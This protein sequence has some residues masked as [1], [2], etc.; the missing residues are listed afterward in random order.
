MKKI[1]S[2]I[3]LAGMLVSMSACRDESLNP[4]P[5]WEYAVHGFLVWDGV[6]FNGKPLS[7]PQP[8]E[9]DYTRNFTPANT[10]NSKVNMKIR[11]VSLDNKLTV[12]KVEIYVRMVEYYND[13]EGNP[14]T[15]DLSG[16]GKGRLYSTLTAGSN[17]QYTN[18]SIEAS[19]VYELYKNATVKYDKVNAV[20]VFNNPARPRPAG[21]RFR[22]D[23]TAGYGD[24][25]SDDFIVTFKLYTADGKVFETWEP[26]SICGDPTPV[27]EANSN[28]QLTFGV[29]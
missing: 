10:D 23:E 24:V 6:A 9:V 19:K 29:Y 12:N 13:P 16:N 14:K 8:Y 3:T 11:W 5:A 7:R 2:L 22:T 21:N 25:F 4:V 27:S 17:R 18:F 26:S 28:C 20:P 15:A 1:L